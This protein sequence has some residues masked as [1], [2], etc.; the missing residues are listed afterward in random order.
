M[1]THRYGISLWVFNSIA[2][3]LAQQ[4]SEMSSWTQEEKIPYLQASMYYFVYHTNIIVWEEKLT[5]LMN[6]NKW[7]NNPQ[8]TII[9]CIG[10]NS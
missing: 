3:E 4:M 8:L 7:I 5:S 10:A 9:E 2:H 1:G 6:E